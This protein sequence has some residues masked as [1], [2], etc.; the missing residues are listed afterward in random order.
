MYHGEDIA[1]SAEA[2]WNNQFREG[3]MPEEIEE[4]KVLDKHM[5]LVDLLINSKMATSKSE[6]RRL[7]EQGG[8]K[9]DGSV[10]LLDSQP[11]FADG[12]ILQVGKRRYL[13]LKVT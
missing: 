3:A 1:L 10:Q 11:V 4:F 13:K 5:P 8:V 12:D 7:I 2:A 9:L 6:A